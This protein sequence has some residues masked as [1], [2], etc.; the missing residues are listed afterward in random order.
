MSFD[1]KWEKE[2]YQ[3]G[4]QVNKYPFHNLVSSI[5]RIFREKNIKKSRALDLGC[6]T[7]N[8]LKFLLD[9]GF[10]EIIA[11]DGSK[12]AITLAK[13]FVKSKK[14]RFFCC[15]LDN[16][17]FAKNEFDLI[18][19]RGALT[20][21]KKNFI[22]KIYNKTLEGLKSDGF[23]ISHVFSKKHSEY[24]KQK[25]KKAFKASMQVN[26]QMTATFFNESEIKMM[27]KNFK[28]IS[29]SESTEKNF[30]NKHSTSYWH[31]IAQK[32]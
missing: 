24:K 21:N 19:D 29:L 12:S 11:V 13:R 32:R 8:N 23:F 16:F 1:K 9:Y 15:D 6:G 30:L 5:N 7:G 25:N 31:V 10:K 20:H 18:I 22:K 3:K 28:I 2:I 4:R 26:S 17:K 27:F 14:C